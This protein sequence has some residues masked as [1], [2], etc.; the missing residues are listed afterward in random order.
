MAWYKID[1]DLYNK[2]PVELSAIELKALTVVIASTKSVH[3]QRQI[4]VEL[5][6][7]IT[8]KSFNE[9]CQLV[10]DKIMNKIM[11]SC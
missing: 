10:G 1:P 2:E 5:M 8:E 7:T 3:N 6:M 11:I 4:I 9:L